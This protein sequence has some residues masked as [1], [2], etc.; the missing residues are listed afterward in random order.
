MGTQ[1][2][3]TLLSFVGKVLDIVKAGRSIKIILSNRK[4]KETFYAF[5]VNKVTI[6]SNVNIGDKICVAYHKTGKDNYNKIY[7]YETVPRSVPELKQIQIAVGRLT[8]LN[9]TRGLK[10][11]LKNEKCIAFKLAR[12][13][14]CYGYVNEDLYISKWM[15]KDNVVKLEMYED[16]RGIPDRPTYKIISLWGE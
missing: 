1:V 12:G 5:D 10:A 3:D 2:P 14:V 16:D 4:Q 6:L 7:Y 9:N 8:N 11:S 15:Q 13:K